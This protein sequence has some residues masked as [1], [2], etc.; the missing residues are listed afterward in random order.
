MLLHLEDLDAGTS[1]GGRIWLT[2]GEDAF[3]DEGWYDLPGILL[4]A[5]LPALR[6]FADGHTDSCKLTFMDGPYAVRLVRN[7]TAVDVRCMEHGK[8]VLDREGIDLPGFRDSV[9]RC[10]RTYKRIKYL[11]NK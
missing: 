3:P 8:C 4:E 10:V 9:Q 5:W 6:S 2:V 11:E 1:M 7:E